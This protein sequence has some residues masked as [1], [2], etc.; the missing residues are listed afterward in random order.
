MKSYENKISF[1]LKET[2]LFE[3]GQEIDEMVSI[4][5]DPDIVVESFED[6]V[7]IRGIIE[8]SGE[9]FRKRDGENVEETFFENES[10]RYVERIVNINRD[11]NHFQHRFPVDISVSKERIEDV[12]EI[13]VTVDAF[14]YNLKENNT[15]TIFATLYIHGILPEAKSN[16]E[17]ATERRPIAAFSDS[18]E[19]GVEKE[20]E[21]FVEKM[22]A[23]D[24]EK[25]EEKHLPQEQERN[26]VEE[27]IE[28][29]P[30]EKTLRLIKGRKD[31]KE[32]DEPVVE[33]IA[34]ETTKT[35]AK[36]NEEEVTE[37]REIP[38]ETY[39]SSTEDTEDDEI[40]I[41]LNEADDEDEE[42]V[43]DVTF[44]AELF[45]SEEETYTTVTIYIAQKDDTIESIAKQ[46]D[47]PVLQL[48]KDNKMSMDAIEEGQLIKIRKRSG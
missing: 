20:E 46:Y 31:E 10:F 35:E 48:L 47:I 39:E 6:Y 16:E 29:E 41:E 19:E 32:K 25:E 27:K 15:L 44:L 3:F 24:D 18:D 37:T 34:E 17:E 12:D 26:E 42:E 33:D 4:S 30:R 8:L 2:L 9:Y 13:F 11:M 36:G 22:E 45:D 7:Q 28:Q 43:H 5:L 38:L 1:D 14:D 21:S 40:Q 23:N